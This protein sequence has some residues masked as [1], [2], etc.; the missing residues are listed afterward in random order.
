MAKIHTCSSSCRHDPKI[1]RSREQELTIDFHCHFFSPRVEEL[2]ADARQK[3]AEREFLLRTL[4]QEALN[5]NDE[6]MFPVAFRS[7]STLEERIQ[8]MD[9]MG[10]DIQVLSPSPTQF[11]YWANELLAEKITQVLNEE[12][13][14]TCR[15]HRQRFKGLGTVA[16]QHPELAVEQLYHAVEKL[17]LCGVEVSSLVNGTDLVAA[18]LEPFWAAAEKLGCI[19]FLHPLGT[20][21]GER[22]AVDYLSNIIGQPLETTIALT[23]LIFDGVFDRYPKLRVLA[24]HGGGFLATYSGRSQHGAYARPDVGRTVKRAMVEYLKTNV[25]FDTLV[26]DPKILRHLIETFGATRIVVGTDYAFD[27]GD[28]SVHEMVNMI[29]KITNEE[30]A[31]ILGKN[32]LSLLER[33]QIS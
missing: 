6:V 13:A 32:A 33:T 8:D 4:G 1:K 28:Y 2:V 17:G 14:I 20:T 23:K 7:M 30:R 18:S 29:P 19:I 12:I 16:L 3:V 15:E 21:L 27:M 26:Y 5:Y 24:A 22:L 31:M 25:W 10:V 11:Y 9:A